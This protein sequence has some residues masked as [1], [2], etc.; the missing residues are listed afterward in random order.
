MHWIAKIFI[1]IAGNSLALWVANRYVPGFV[2][3]ATFLQLLLIAL[4]LALLNFILKPVLE[5]I[6]SPIIIITL[7]LGIILVN[8]LIL[9]LLPILANHLDFLHGSITIQTTLALLIATLIISVIN[10]LIHLVT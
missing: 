2:L 4:I 7:G 5:L 3:N 1:V 9:Y 6:F 10:F 8:A